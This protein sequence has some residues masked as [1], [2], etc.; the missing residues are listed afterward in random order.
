MKKKY[1]S[2]T[3]IVATIGPAS[4]SRKVLSQM[5]DAGLDIAR[6]NFSHAQYDITKK[7]LE[8]IRALAKKKKRKVEILQDL[9]G[10]RI[11]T[12]AD[13]P[14]RGIALKKGSKINIGFGKYKKG[15][16]PID[17]KNLV[18]DIDIG[19]FIF[20][21]DGVIELEVIEKEK[22]KAL[23]KVLVGG[24]VYARKGV[25]I[26]NA[27]L[28]ISP[29]TE[30]DK[31]DIKWGLKNKVDYIALSFVKGPEDIVYLRSLVKNK[32]IKLIAKIERPQALKNLRRILKVSDGVMVARGDLGIEIRLEKVPAA[33]RKIVHMVHKKRKIVIIA[34][35]MMESMLNNPHPTR[36]EVS[37][38]DTAVL[39]KASGVMLSEE[40][41]MGKYPVEAIKIMEKICQQAEKE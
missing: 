10:P 34:T 36:A 41:A 37:D 8:D 16:L 17:Y 33:Q 15:F 19:T 26:P 39:E 12:G 35:Q 38:I 29:I 14:K 28:K 40:T 6:F 4:G 27:H 30:K 23:V 21:S 18:N 1:F 24:V 25:N 11:R 31:E 32:K 22:N 9:Q 13:V 2:R 7:W 5:I 20:L 3:K